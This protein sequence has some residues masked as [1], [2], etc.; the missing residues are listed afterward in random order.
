MLR[1]ENL[2]EFN[3]DEIRL[4]LS[5]TLGIGQKALSRQYFISHGEEKLV[6]R[7]GLLRMR[8]RYFSD[9]HSCSFLWSQSTLYGYVLTIRGSAWTFGAGVERC[10]S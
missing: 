5:T 3:L 6:G 8:L 2:Q 4:G 1:V 9:W 10:E 7:N